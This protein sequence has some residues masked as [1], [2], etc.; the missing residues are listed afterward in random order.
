MGMIKAQRKWNC[1]ICDGVVLTDGISIH[2]KC[3]TVPANLEKRLDPKIWEVK[4]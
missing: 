2:C 3:G 1:A 4:K